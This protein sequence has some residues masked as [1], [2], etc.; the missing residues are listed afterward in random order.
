M[1]RLLILLT[2]VAIALVS[3]SATATIRE[4]LRCQLNEGKSLADLEKAMDEWRALATKAGYADYVAEILVPVHASDVA[5]GRFYWMGTVPSYERLG[6]GYNWWLTNPDAIEM[7]DKLN[8]VYTCETR[9]SSK[10]A[11]SK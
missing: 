5:P 1:K 6:A 3:A 8:R 9:E 2:A 10:V 11:F 7:A 4:F